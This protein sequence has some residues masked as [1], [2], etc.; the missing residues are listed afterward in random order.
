MPANSKGD[1]EVTSATVGS[2]ILLQRAVE[3]RPELLQSALRRAGALGRGERID[4]RSPLS[5]QG[6]REYRD[7]EALRQL[8]IFDSLRTP[9]SGFWPARGPVWDALGVVGQ[10]PVLLEAKAHIPEAASPPTKASPSSRELI[11]SSLNSARRFYAPRSRADWSKVFF[12]Y[13]N[14]LAHQHFLREQNHIQSRLVFLYFTN[15]ADV[16]GPATEEEWRGAIRLLHAQLGIS[17]DLKRFGVFDA[18]LDARS[19]MDAA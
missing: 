19:V 17:A 18:Y 7:A 4:W 9:L 13:A 6:Y 3:H 1:T 15:A 14:R 16:E 8:G 11:E 12:Q 5:T 10:V 2:Q